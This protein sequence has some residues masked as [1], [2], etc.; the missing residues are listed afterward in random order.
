MRQRLRQLQSSLRETSQA[1][2]WLT[3]MGDEW[4]APQQEEEFMPTML[5][6]HQR[7]TFCHLFQQCL[8]GQ[9]GN[10]FQ[11]VGSSKFKAT[12]AVFTNEQSRY[13]KIPMA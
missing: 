1:A 6:A 2:A 8:F 9:R 13:Q 11:S 7:F 4:A 10:P 5:R 3:G 12:A